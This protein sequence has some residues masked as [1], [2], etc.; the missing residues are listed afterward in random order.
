IKY[1]I[2][3]FFLS[4]CFLIIIC[5]ITFNIR[6]AA[7]YGWMGTNFKNDAFKEYYNL[8]NDSAKKHLDLS[9]N[10]IHPA[11]NPIIRFNYRGKFIIFIYKINTIDNIEI[12]DLI[13]D[14]KAYESMN[15][16]RY[17]RT[18]E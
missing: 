16:L 3:L 4:V 17:F 14:G 18:D 1:V 7:P 10:F 9:V 11:K 8:F 5:S 6:R 12:K 13:K 2:N 15:K